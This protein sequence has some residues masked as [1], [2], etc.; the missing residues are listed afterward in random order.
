MSEEVVKYCLHGI[1]CRIRAGF[2][3]RKGPRFRCPNSPCQ[4]WESSEDGKRIDTIV[5]W[6]DGFLGPIGSAIAYHDAVSPDSPRY[7]VALLVLRYNG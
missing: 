5:G 3:I 4:Q 1:R 7:L 2:D 6:W